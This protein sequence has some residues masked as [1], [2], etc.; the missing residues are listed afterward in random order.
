[1]FDSVIVGGGPAGLSTALLLGRSRRNVLVLDSGEYRNAPSHAAHSFLTR[2]GISPAE[3]RRIAREQLAAYPGVRITSGRVE[4]A[5]GAAGAFT[6]HLTGGETVEGRTVVFA[7]GVRDEL[8]PLDGLADIW[9]TSA[10]HCPYCDGWENRDRAMAF[11]GP[12]ESAPMMAMHLGPLL[13]NLSADL[14]MLTNGPSALGDSE[15][16]RLAE[17][18]VTVDERPITRLVSRD[19][20]LQAIEMT[21]G[22]RVERE[23]LFFA[24][25]PRPNSALAAS[26]GCELTNEPPIVG[27]LRV[28]GLGQT[29][30]PG[31]YAAGDITTPMSQ[32]ATAVSTGAIAGTAVNLFLTA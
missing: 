28:D 27:L 22:S 13:R 5:S 1:M 8:P 2:D 31:V 29:T 17:L 14:I 19:G 6:L 15:R 25:A 9:G 12:D 4:S 3:L 16:A 23:A 11:Y 7:N 20:E 24:P 10:F 32:I 26:L 18:G 21:D 30:V